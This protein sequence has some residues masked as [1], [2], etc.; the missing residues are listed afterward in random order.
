MQNNNFKMDVHS[1]KCLHEEK[2]SQLN[3]IHQRTRKIR[4]NETQKWYTST[5]EKWEKKPKMWKLNSM[6]L[7]ING[8]MKKSENT[9]KHIKIKK[10]MESSKSSSK[11]EVHSKKGLLQE[12]RKIT[13]E[14]T[15]LQH[16]EKWKKNKQTQCQ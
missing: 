13:N 15:N 16:K 12:I 7:K 3:F 4:T 11:R 5:I 2:K 9:S 1:D 14:Q 6:L 10:S 8:S